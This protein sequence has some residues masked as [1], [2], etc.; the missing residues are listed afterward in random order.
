MAAHSND[1]QAVWSELQQREAA[2]MQLQK[3]ADALTAQKEELQLQLSVTSDKAE[4]LTLQLQKQKDARSE[5]ESQHGKQTAELGLVHKQASDLV[6]E[7]KELQQK[8]DAILLDQKQ[9][10]SR[11]EVETAAAAKLL[12]AARTEVHKLQVS[13]FVH[14]GSY[15]NGSLCLLENILIANI[16]LRWSDALVALARMSN[17]PGMLAAKMC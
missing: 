12:L 8:L 9:T 7:T 3:A 15:A 16:V 1:L 14:I 10:Q 13:V 6:G 17:H 4:E 2:G 11:Q 5:L